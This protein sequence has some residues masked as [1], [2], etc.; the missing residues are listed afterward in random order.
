MKFSAWSDFFTSEEKF[1][2]NVAALDTI[3]LLDESKAEDCMRN[4]QDHKDL[5]ALIVD[6]VSGELLLVHHISRIGQSLK[7]KT[8]NNTEKV[9]ALSGSGT[10]ASPIRL[11][12]F[13]EAFSQK[14]VIQGDAPSVDD[15]ETFESLSDFK[16]LEAKKGNKGAFRN[17]LMLPPFAVSAILSSSSTEPAKLAQSIA[18][19]SQ[20][21]KDQLLHH[22]DF[23]EEDHRKAT[24]YMLSFLWCQ[25]KH[26][27]K[28]LPC[29]LATDLEVECWAEEL[30]ASCLLPLSPMLP[31]GSGVPSP[32]DNTLSHLGS[33]I[34]ILHETLNKMNAS[35]SEKRASL[36][37]WNPSPKHSS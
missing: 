24:I 22:D 13:K 26:Q 23:D 4:L 18:A 15:L 10:S 29:G 25:C 7:K 20:S 6:N 30:H 27:L 36:N 32:S 17:I 11:E 19:S 34:H 9:V 33:G 2:D 1:E 16:K 35:K 37:P 31:S 5:A 12:H 28:P 21:A 14:C 3:N 8:S